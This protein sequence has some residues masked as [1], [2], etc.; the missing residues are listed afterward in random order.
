VHESF[1]SLGDALQSQVAV[2]CTALY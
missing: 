1:A 2:T